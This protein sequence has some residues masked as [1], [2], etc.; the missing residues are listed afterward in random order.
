MPSYNSMDCLKPV[1]MTETINKVEVPFGFY[2]RMLFSS[3]SPQDKDTIEIGQIERSRRAAPF[4]REGS[5]ALLIRGRSRSL[6]QVMFPNIRIKKPF[7]TGDVFNHRFTGMSPGAIYDNEMTARLMQ[8]R[9]SDDLEDMEA[10]IQNAEEYLCAA[11]V[12]GVVSYDVPG[13]DSFIIDYK[14]QFGTT[15]LPVVLI[16]ADLWTAATSLPWFNFLQAK[17]LLARRAGGGFSV[18]DAVMGDDAGDAFMKNA[19]VFDNLNTQQGIGLGG[20][21]DFAKELEE[22]GSVQFLG[23]FMN[24]RCWIYSATIEMSDYSTVQ[25]QPVNQVEFI[26]NTSKAENVLY[27][28]GITDPRAI[29]AGGPRMKRFAKSWMDEDPGT[30]YNLSTSRPLAVPRRPDSMQTYQVV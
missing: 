13:Q 4:V 27:Y 28:G 16:A 2:K 11:A 22:N 7:N 17:R 30:I 18:T 9:I 1:N 23:R 25:L 8:E 15:L 5:S 29:E 3:E 20:D 26:S 12:Q 19:T 21:L 6:T 14:G 24:I 10:Q